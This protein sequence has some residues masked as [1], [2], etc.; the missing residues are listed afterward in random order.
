MAA[1]SRALL[2]RRL[3]LLFR[4]KVLPFASSSSSCC[5]ST[6]NYG[7]LLRPSAWPPLPLPRPGGEWRC[8]FHDGRPRGPLW[9]SKKLIGKEAL[10]AIQGLKRFKG[11]DERLGEFL[12]RHVA[13]LLKADKLA[14]LGEL[15]RQEEVDLAVK[16]FRTIQKDDWYKPDVYMYKDLIVALAKIKKMDEAM[17]IWGE[18]E[19]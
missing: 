13:R 19:R 5:S 3:S 8:A 14:V 7:L 2:A 1:T 17:V 12:K 18:H 16:M 6:S 9:R 4:F 15:E 11:D 10:F